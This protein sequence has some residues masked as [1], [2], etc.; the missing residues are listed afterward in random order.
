MRFIASIVAAVFLTLGTASCASGGEAGAPGAPTATATA[1]PFSVL[2]RGDAPDGASPG[3]RPV[4]DRKAY[5][6][7]GEGLGFSTTKQPP[8]D[9]ASEMVVAIV[10]DPKPTAGWK[11]EVTKVE[12]AGDGLLVTVREQGPAKGAV[13][14]QVLTTPFIA[15]RVPRVAGEIK[16]Q[17][18]PAK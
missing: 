2:A 9:F 4:R 1:L 6:A 15:I 8:P 7:L 11:L 14:A 13:T 18:E 10:G 3:A 12:R 5:D 17:R 16:T